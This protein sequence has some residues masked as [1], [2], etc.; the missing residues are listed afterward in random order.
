MYI[1]LPVGPQ[2]ILETDNV[3]FDIE[4][5]KEI[6]HE[7]LRKHYDSLGDLIHSDLLQKVTQ[8][9]YAA[10]LVSVS[11]NNSPNFNNLMNEYG[12]VLK[13]CRDCS[14]FITYCRTFIR[15]LS[16]QGG[17]WKMISEVIADDWDKEIKEQLHISL[18]FAKH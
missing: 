15:I 17:P 1:H 12:V 9:M 16:D 3:T 14:K 13:V 4:K 10:G 18:K 11:V 7:I 5:A 6:I 2:A 8:R